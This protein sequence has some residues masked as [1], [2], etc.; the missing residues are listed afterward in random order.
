[1]CFADLFFVI[2]LDISITS[3]CIVKFFSIYVN[4]F[5]PM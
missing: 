5:I 2:L 1:M 4:S 3:A